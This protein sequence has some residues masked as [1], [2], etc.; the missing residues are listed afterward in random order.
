[1][2]SVLELCPNTVARRSSRYNA[3]PKTAAIK[4]HLMP[5]NYKNME[6]MRVNYKYGTPQACLPYQVRVVHTHTRLYI[7]P[8][9]AL[10]PRV[11]PLE[12]RI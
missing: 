12:S 9:T 6:N 4:N 1:M 8:T 2:G 3:A 7:P 11:P 5:W 10:P